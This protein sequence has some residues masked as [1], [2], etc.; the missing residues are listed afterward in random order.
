M[1]VDHCID[2]LDGGA[3]HLKAEIRPR[4]DHHS[5]AFAIGRNAL[6]HRGCACAGS[7]GWPDRS[8]PIAG[9]ARRSGRRAEQPAK[10]VNS[11][12]SPKL[13]RPLAM[14]PG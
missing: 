9:D 14:E 2:P 6:D 3:Q 8:S 12:R 7:W 1:R 10:M 5:R 11:S 4:I 13:R